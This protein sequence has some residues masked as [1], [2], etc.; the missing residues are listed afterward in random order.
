M[1]NLHKTL[2]LATFLLGGCIGE[3]LSNCPQ[4]QNVIINFSYKEAGIE[5]FSKTISGVHLF[6][7]TQEDGHFMQ[8][9]QI[10]QFGLN[11]LQG[12]E[13][14]LP[15]GKYQ[16][17]CFG[18]VDQYTQFST[19]NPSCH[20]DNSMES[21]LLTSVKSPN[22]D[23]AENEDK[24]YY[25]SY[26]NAKSISITVPS[27]SVKEYTV[28]FKAAHST[29]DVYATGFVDLSQQD[30]NL[31]PSVELVNVPSKYDFT[32]H[33]FGE[34][35]T[36]KQTAHKIN[37]EGIDTEVVRFNTPLFEK[38]NNLELVLRK[39]STNQVLRRVRLTDL[40]NQ[41][42]SHIDLSSTQPVNIKIEFK[43]LNGEIIIAIP[44]W[45]DDVIHPEI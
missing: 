14:Y 3:D 23:Y 44:T 10:G 36:Y 40:I 42:Y 12:T 21:Y 26:G 7:F 25:G 30:T 8:S 43:Y 31:S 6:V 18:N 17:V 16:L 5:A 33:T 24:L 32:L 20:I 15:K 27:T 38:E 45:K 22:S 41:Y 35:I 28:N 9:K 2:L 34:A 19:L 37:V 29:I 1:R 13:L 11:Q 4:T 39:Q